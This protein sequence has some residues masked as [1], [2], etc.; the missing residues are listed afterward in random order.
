MALTIA[1]VVNDEAI[2]ILEWIAY[3]ALRGVERFI[4]YDNNSRFAAGTLSPHLESGVVILEDATS[5]CHMPG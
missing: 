1:T 3:H 4:I 2:Y 5:L